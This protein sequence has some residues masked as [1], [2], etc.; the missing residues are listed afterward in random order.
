MNTN[1]KLPEN[2]NGA[3]SRREKSRSL[4]S[5]LIWLF[6]FAFLLNWF[7]EI[8]QV[9]AYETMAGFS[10][11]EKIYIITRASFADA[12]ITLGIYGIGAAAARQSRWAMDGG[13]K[14]YLVFAL[15]G[16]AAATIIEWIALAF[17]FWRYHGQMPIVPVLGVGLSPFLQLTLLAPAAL[18]LAVWRSG[19][20]LE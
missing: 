10:R 13:W 1:T 4:V 17:D 9:P 7:W 6:V 3:S 16:A 11:L 8:L 14:C 15:L 5:F 12:A 19:R 18:R 20:K 2:K